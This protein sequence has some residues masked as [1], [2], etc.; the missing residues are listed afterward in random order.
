MKKV[1]FNQDGLN[2][3]FYAIKNLTKKEFKIQ[4]NL[5]Q[6]YT[7]E[8]VLENFILNDDQ[9]AYVNSIP[10][11][12]YSQIG[13]FA[14]IALDNNMPFKLEIPEVYA[15]PIASK[16][17]LHVYVEGGGTY[18]QENPPKITDFEIGIRLGG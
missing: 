8:W 14:K 7:A 11:E 13:L 18:D 12:I 6:F 2:S 16:R 15:P 17:L 5:I 10:K 4:T 3:L 1:P 9:I